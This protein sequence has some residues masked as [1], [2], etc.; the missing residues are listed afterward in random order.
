MRHIPY[1]CFIIYSV[2]MSTWWIKCIQA[3]TFGYQFYRT[4]LLNQ[5]PAG[6]SRDALGSCRQGQGCPGILQAKAGTP[7]GPTGKGRDALGS[8]RQ[9]QGRHGVLQARAGTPWGPAG[10]GREPWGPAGKDRD[11]LGSCRQEQRRRGVLQARTGTLWVPAL[12]DAVG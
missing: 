12:K 11:A 2:P 10:K 9:G 8:C 5:R 6:K 3:G 7:C 4:G 1:L